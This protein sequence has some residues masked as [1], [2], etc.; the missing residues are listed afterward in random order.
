MRRNK[1][2]LLI[3]SLSEKQLVMS[4]VYT[5]LLL[6]ILASIIS[7]FAFKDWHSFMSLFNWDFKWSIIGLLS[8]L[9]I[10]CID[11]FLMKYLPARFYDD[12]GINEK[13]FSKLNFWQITVLVLL[14]AIAEEWLFRGIVQYHIGLI[15]GAIVFSAVHLRYWSHWYLI[16][17]IVILSIWIG[18]VFTWSGQLLTPV[19]IMHFVID[20]MLGIS[21][22]FQAKRKVG[23]EI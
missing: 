8:G 4:V 14:I 6:I 13:I 9:L 10:A 23:N 19:I 5:Q 7:I 3:R 1:Q 15:P 11:L 20:F 21:I 2:A 17:N 12:G 22:R 16:L 18:L